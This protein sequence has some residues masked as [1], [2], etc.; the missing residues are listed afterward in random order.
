MCFVFIWEQ[1]ATCAIYIINWLV[2]T[3][4]MKRVYCA[5]RTG[6]LT[7]AVCASYLKGQHYTAHCVFIS[8]DYVILKCF[9]NDSHG[10]EH[11]RTICYSTYTLIF[12][13]VNVNFLEEFWTKM[14]RVPNNSPPNTFLAFHLYPPSSLFVISFGKI[15]KILGTLLRR[16]V[17]KY[18][19]LEL[20]S[21]SRY[22]FYF[23]KIT[24]KSTITINL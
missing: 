1:T 13:F 8:R 7:T 10:S 16:G 9:Y 12:I 14:F 5:V 18:L 3:T 4:E 19:C 22:H 6:S 20:D 15:G 21:N 23:E 2:F 24:K 17:D 11:R